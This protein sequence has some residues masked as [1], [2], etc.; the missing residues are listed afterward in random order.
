MVLPRRRSCADITAHFANSSDPLIDDVVGNTIS[1]MNTAAKLLENER[2]RSKLRGIGLPI[3][4]QAAGYVS[5]KEINGLKKKNSSINTKA[6]L[7]C[8]RRGFLPQLQPTS[9]P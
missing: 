2:P 7:M 1:T 4:Q 9:L 5:R 8:P 3:A 6:S